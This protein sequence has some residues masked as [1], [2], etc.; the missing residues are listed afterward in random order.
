MVPKKGVSGMK[1]LDN[2]RY[3]AVNLTIEIVVSLPH[4]IHEKQ[5]WAS[6]S[7]FQKQPGNGAQRACL[8]KTDRVIGGSVMQPPHP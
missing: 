8:I 6:V 1:N 4:N 3:A 7:G 2:K 5:D